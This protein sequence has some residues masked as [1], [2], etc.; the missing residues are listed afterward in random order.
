[1]VPQREQ[2][3]EAHLAT[4][5]IKEPNGPE[6]GGPGQ[7]ACKD[8]IHHRS[9]SRAR[10]GPQGTQGGGEDGVKEGLILPYLPRAAQAGGRGADLITTHC[11]STQLSSRPELAGPFSL[12]NMLVAGLHI[13]RLR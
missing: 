3:Q 11:P 4:L 10:E 8:F 2:G 1:M 12:V 7:P 13:S 6:G 5:Q 9:G